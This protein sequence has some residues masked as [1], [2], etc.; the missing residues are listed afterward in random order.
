MP[1]STIGRWISTTTFR[2]SL[3]DEFEGLPERGPLLK[4]EQNQ[5]PITDQ[6]IDITTNG[7]ELRVS[8]E[9]QFPST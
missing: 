5:L 8:V 3:T 9:Y 7:P 2:R 1:V 6:N 4:A